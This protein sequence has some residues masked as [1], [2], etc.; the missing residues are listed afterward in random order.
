MIAKIHEA[1]DVASNMAAITQEQSAS[2]TEIE[3]SAINMQQLTE[4]VSL[5]SMKVN[6]D[7]KELA[8]T[9]NVLKKIY[10]GL[11]FIFLYAPIV[12]LMV[13]SFNG[14][15]FYYNYYNKEALNSSPDFA[16]RYAGAISNTVLHPV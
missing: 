10:V 9:A 1:N 14:K 5:H 2:A 3:S 11:I 8:K 12:T 16:L 15:I 7:S 13:L 6:T 4:A